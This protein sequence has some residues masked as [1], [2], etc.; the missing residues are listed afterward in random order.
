VRTAAEAAVD[1]AAGPGGPRAGSAVRRATALAGGWHAAHPLTE[2]ARPPD[3][4]PS[5]SHVFAAAGGGDAEDPFAGG[6]VQPVTCPGCEAHYGLPPGLTPPWGGR[7]RC[8]KCR[9]AFSVGV[10]AEADR[11]VAEVAAGDPA[12]WE[13]ACADRSLWTMWGDALLAAY[14]ALRE[15]FGPQVASRAFRRALEDAAP[16]VPWFA[17]PTPASPLEPEPAAAGV[18]G[19]MFER[20]QGS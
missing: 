11:L 1:G 19:T 16:G 10:R 8:P 20:R 7:V 6:P 2:S 18:G 3:A 9:T 15:R 12:G 14:G 5:L 4:A 17:P 13:R